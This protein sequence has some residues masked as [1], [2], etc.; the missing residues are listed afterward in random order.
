VNTIAFALPNDEKVRELKGSK[1]IILKNVITAKYDKILLPIARLLITPEQLPMVQPKAFLYHTILHELAHPLGADYTAPQQNR[2]TIRKSLKETY[3]LNEEAK[4]D[5][6][7]LFNSLLMMKKG[8]IDPE[9]HNAMFVTQLAS[10]FRAMRFGT[11][12]AHG[13]A[14]LIQFNYLKE[15]GGIVETGGR[16]GVD[17]GKFAPALTALVKDILEIQGTGDYARSKAFNEKYGRLD[18]LLR[19]RLQQLQAIPVDIKPEFGVLRELAK[20]FH[21]PSLNQD[22]FLK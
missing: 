1:K 17:F 10:M 22:R 11:E 5:T 4:A 19:D 18:P 8:I 12:E 14:N 16:Y 3:S 2:V 7:G 6:V 13:G 20:R 9:L 21:D 15:K